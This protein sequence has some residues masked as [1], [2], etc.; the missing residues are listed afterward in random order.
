MKRM[1]PLA[2][3][4]A[5][6]VVLSAAGLAQQF[7][8]PHP[9]HQG[10]GHQAVHA[11]VIVGAVLPL[12]FRRRFPFTTVLL[13]A[14]VVGV[15][16]SIGPF[17]SLDP[18]PASAFALWFAVF[19]ATA[20]RGTAVGLASVGIAW[21][22]AT[23]TLRPWAIPVAA[24]LP[25]YPYALIAFV[26]GRAEHERRE[27]SELLERRLDD[28]QRHREQL[29]QLAIQRARTD[30]ARDLRDVVVDSLH[31]MRELASDAARRLKARARDAA[32][33]LSATEAAG[34]YA[35]TEMRRLLQV[36]REEPAAAQPQ[37][38]VR[39]ARELVGANSPT[40]SVL[41][42][43]TGS[44]WRMDLVLV[45]ALSAGVL[46][47]LREWSHILGPNVPPPTFSV[48]AYVWAVGWVTLLFLR[49]PAPLFTALAM[50]ATAFLQ[51][52]PL[53]YF[54]PVSDIVALQISVYTVGAH[55]PN[56]RHTV[57]AAILGGIGI[58]SVPP[59][60]VSAST[61]GFFVIVAVTLMGAAYVGMV[62][63]ERRRLIRELEQSLG[64][65]EEEQRTQVTLRLH[66]D[67]L[68]LAREMHDLVGHSVT[69]MLVQASAARTVA[70]TDPEAALAAVDVVL[71]S[72]TRATAELDQ[73]LAHLRG[74]D[75]QPAPLPHRDIHEL[76]S[77]ARASG[78]D[79]Q[80]EEFGQARPPT[81][82]TVSIFESRIVQE[83]LTNVRKHA[84]GAH[85][86]VHIRHDP[87]AV[88]VRID[89]DGGRSQGELSSL[90]AGQGLVGMRERVALVGGRFH[91]GP[92][93]TGGFEVEAVMPLEVAS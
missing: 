58:V 64:V 50:A 18:S 70:V 22:A 23:L 73:L 62:V 15:A 25:N 12:L 90:G 85:V 1:P 80:L 53:R 46:L 44:G 43:L 83:A 6:V 65:L 57:V 84:P 74:L 45:T 78:L 71:A 21:I 91:A 60:P 89:N 11:A 49:R 8:G 10:A 38:N 17:L 39:R 87:T 81:G 77:E 16:G 42:R 72:E 34:R 88:E 75:G 4:A 26:A 35:L 66:R 13:L 56:R 79:V 32:E 59:P 28:L 24:W 27:L 41:R 40:G 86:Q 30:L 51:T 5:I 68:A 67:R 61:L 33:S 19:N 76:V 29:Q 63:G 7:G 82:G 37:T 52:F 3:D 54:T 2:V 14:A 47:E 55:D 20:E 31:Q 36:L 92:K 93:Q 9:E 48:G 69:L